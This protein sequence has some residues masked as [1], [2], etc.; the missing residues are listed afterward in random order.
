M[1][2]KEAGSGPD[3]PSVYAMTRADRVILGY[4]AFCGFLLILYLSGNP[5]LALLLGVPP[6]ILGFGIPMLLHKRFPSTQ[7]YSAL[8]VETQRRMRMSVI[9]TFA[10]LLAYRAFTND[11]FGFACT[12]MLGGAIL[13]VFSLGALQ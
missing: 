3:A 1:N 13:L 7:N 11:W 4:G 10:V 5:L 12:V 9:F 8:P 6:G 2:P